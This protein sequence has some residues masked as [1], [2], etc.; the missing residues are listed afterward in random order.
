[1]QSDFSVP[2]SSL[3]HCRAFAAANASLGQFDW[4]FSRNAARARGRAFQCPTNIFLTATEHKRKPSRSVILRIH[5]GPALP[6]A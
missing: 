6:C 4:R 5:P 3:R 2:D 1:V